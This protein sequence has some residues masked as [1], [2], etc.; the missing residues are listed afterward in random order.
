MNYLRAQISLKTA[1][2]QIQKSL[3]IEKLL[4]NLK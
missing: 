2:H 3:Q 4:L 1:G